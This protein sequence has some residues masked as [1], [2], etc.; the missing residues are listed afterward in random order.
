[1][2]KDNFKILISSAPRYETLMG[3]VTEYPILRK[4]KKNLYYFE[5][6]ISQLFEKKMGFRLGAYSDNIQNIKGT[7][8]VFDGETTVFFLKWLKENN[9]DTRLIYYYWNAI[10]KYS[11][12]PEEISK[13]GY[14][15]WSFDP[16][17][18]ERYGIRYNKEFFCDSWYKGLK[19]QEDFSY[20]ISFI[21]RDKNGRMNEI[22]MLK[23]MIGN[24][25]RWDL[26]F[27]AGKWWK[28]FFNKRYQAYLTYDQMINRQHKAKAVLDFASN[29]QSSITLRFYDALCNGQKVITNNKNII[30]DPIYN[31]ENIFVLGID[32]LQNLKSFLNKPFQP[33]DNKVI[34]E[35]SILGWKKRFDEVKDA[36]LR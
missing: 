13:L 24:D 20:D 23:Q 6:K 14:E 3:R 2:D 27:T 12:M 8:V 1:M 4:Y 36:K 19:R 25:F 29:K 7:V 18:C 9:P 17:D 31:K 11:I 5:Y 30:N 26:Y 16:E 33:M 32:D 28:G 21:G 34:E 15:V 22:L 10:T 35:C